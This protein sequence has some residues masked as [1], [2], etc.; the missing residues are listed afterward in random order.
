MQT[1]LRSSVTISPDSRRSE[2]GAVH[3]LGLILL[4]AILFL[5]ALY[6]TS[7]FDSQKVGDT[8]KDG[9]RRLESKVDFLELRV[10]ELEQAV[11]RQRNQ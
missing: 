8:L 9:F 11:K 10:R 7:G 5:L 2:R 1:K 3:F 6:W 4:V